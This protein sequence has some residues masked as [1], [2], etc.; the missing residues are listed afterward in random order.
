MIEPFIAG[1][2]ENAASKELGM[3][4]KEMKKKIYLGGPT[5]GKRC[6]ISE[7]EAS[8][9]HRPPAGDNSAGVG[10]ALIITYTEEIARLF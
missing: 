4:V 3:F 5:L 6:V 9:I 2:T 7:S 8:R 1:S 10:I